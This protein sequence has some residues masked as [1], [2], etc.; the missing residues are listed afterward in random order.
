M[1]N[2]Y[3]KLEMEAKN[4]MEGGR[5]GDFGGRDGISSGSQQTDLERRKTLLAKDGV[6]EL[7]EIGEFGLG[8]APILSKPIT[9]IEISKQREEEINKMLVDDD[10]QRPQT[11]DLEDDPEQELEQLRL[12][13][14][15]QKKRKAVDRQSA[16]VEF[17]TLAEGK[18]LEEQIL[19]NRQD[20]KEHK[21]KVKSFTESC[22]NAKKELDVIKEKLDEKAEEKRMTMRDDMAAFEDE[23]EGG[24]G[25]GAQEIIDEEELGWLQKMKEMKK[26]YRLNFDSLKQ[27]KGQ[28]HYIQQTIDTLKQ[29]LVSS[30]EDWFSQTF[31]TEEDFQSTLVIY[32][33]QFK[34]LFQ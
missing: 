29:N 28:V 30:F 31:L 1:K 18:E 21:L 23:G 6:G 14:Q 3:K 33:Y 2:V 11:Q 32:I 22:N 25:H 10:D 15:R 13:Q 12:K 16:F 27:A 9:K 24:E 7:Q 8:I 20:L 19:S 34:H 5:G 4:L 17:K 26:I